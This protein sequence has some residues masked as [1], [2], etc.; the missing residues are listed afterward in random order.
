[1]SGDWGA[2]CP[3]HGVDRCDDFGPKRPE[4]GQDHP[5]VVAAAAQDS[6]ERVAQ[7][8]LEDAAGEA[9]VG[10]HVSNRRLD[11][12]APARDACGVGVGCLGVGFLM[13]MTCYR[14]EE[15]PKW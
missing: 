8:A 9:T 12:A 11:R 14:G 3:E 5:D 13:A 15:T 6:M 10:L 4:V 1:M 2:F 7:R